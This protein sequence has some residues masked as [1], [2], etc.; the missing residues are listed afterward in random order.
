M[1]FSNY[2]GGKWVPGCTGTTF[3]TV[4]PADESVLARIHAAGVEDVDAAVEAATGAFDAWRLTPAPLRG[5]LLYKVGD[6]LKA[7]K[8]ELARLLTQDMGKVISEA[9]GDVQEA[10]DMAYYMGG[11]GRRLL[12][13]TA[14]VEMPNKFG[15]AIRDPSGVV[16]IITPWNFPIA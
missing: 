13:Y 9:R 10:I 8:E 6:L 3:D 15:M 12:G 14:P 1:E 4:N 16:G 11:E 2:I 7:R 5:E